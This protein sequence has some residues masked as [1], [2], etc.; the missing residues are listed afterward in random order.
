[1]KPLI[2]ILTLSLLA[3]CAAPKPAK[4]YDGPTLP[5]EK[6][7]RVRMPNV[8]IWVVAV[9]GK[10]TRDGQGG[11]LDKSELLLA[12][13]S[14]ELTL[15]HT[16]NDG[17]LQHDRADAKLAVTLLAGHVYTVRYRDVRDRRV[18]FFLVDHESTYDKKCA[19]LLTKSGQLI[20]IGDGVA[21]ECY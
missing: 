17:W 2:A 21:P 16:R 3:G 13:G 4:F 1:M 18:E 19:Q 20:Y 8:K 12:P 14:H 6:L 10:S 15:L 5:T 9:D 7:A 11:L